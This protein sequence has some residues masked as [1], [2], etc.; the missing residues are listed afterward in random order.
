M[1]LEELMQKLNEM[2]QKDPSILECKVLLNHG[3]EIEEIYLE[4]YKNV[5]TKEISECIVISN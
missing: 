5:F 2:A 4:K 1:K 3:S